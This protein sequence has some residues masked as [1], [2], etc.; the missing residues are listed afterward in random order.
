[1]FRNLSEII[2]EAR[3]LGRAES[4]VRMNGELDRLMRKALALDRRL[5]WAKHNDA[6]RTKLII[7]WQKGR[8]EAGAI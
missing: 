8:R 6:L 2:E 5:L 1:M 4:F 7:A 3:R